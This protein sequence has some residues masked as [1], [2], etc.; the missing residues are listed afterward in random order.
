MNGGPY[1]QFA[2]FLQGIGGRL[3][4]NSSPFG[5]PRQFAIGIAA[6]RDANLLEF[7]APGI[8]IELLRRG[9]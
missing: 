3:D 4:G 8:D 5:G 7:N 6:G 1:F 2:D 9:F